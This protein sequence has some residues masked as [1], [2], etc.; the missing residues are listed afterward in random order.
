MKINILSKSGHKIV[1]LN[2]RKA[3]RERCLCC[4]AWHPAQVTNC[5][6]TNCQLYPFRSGTGKQNAK[7]RD[8]AI[9]DYCLWCGADQSHEVRKCRVF[10]CSLW[11][12]RKTV[13]DRS[14]ELKNCS[15]IPNIDHSPEMNPSNPIPIYRVD[16]SI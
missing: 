7:A 9:R 16:A 1:N 13:I 12:Y 14:L 5:K 3:I 8:K 10:D 6:L 11:S 4:T 2:R 15:K